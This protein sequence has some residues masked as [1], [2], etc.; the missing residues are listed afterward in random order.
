VATQ[1]SSGIRRHARRAAA[2]AAAVERRSNI[3]WQPTT[4]G[5]IVSR[6]GLKPSVIPHTTQGRLRGEHE[7]QG[8]VLVLPRCH[9]RAGC[10]GSHVSLSQRV[11]ALS[12]RCS[13]KPWSEVPA[14]L[15]ILIMALL[16]LAGGAWLTVAVAQ[17]V[18]LLVPFRQGARWAR[19]AVPSLGLLHYAGVCNAMAHVTLNTPATP[20]WGPT[21]AAIALLLVG[22]GLSIPG[23]GKSGGV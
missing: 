1:V 8:R 10:L 11:H 15:Q 12:R 9:G 23:Q 13:R 14:P 3:G 4:A 2:G 20:P 16:K 21:M 18:L 19:W 17:L 5:G 6:R 22:A 7:I